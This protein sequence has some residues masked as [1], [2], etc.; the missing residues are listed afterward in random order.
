MCVLFGALEQKVLNFSQSAMS[1]AVGGSGSESPPSGFN[2]NK[3]DRLF[4]SLTDCHRRIRGSLDRDIACR[5]LN[6][7]LAQCLVAEACPDESDA[8]RSLC[9]SGGTA[10]KRHQCSQAKLALS[11][12]I[13]SHQPP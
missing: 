6:R 3:C 11:V 8:V 2:L 12:C 5:H 13:A 1:F 4:K 7:S 10:L 9:S